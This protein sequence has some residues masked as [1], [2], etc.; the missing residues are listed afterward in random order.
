MPKRPRGGRDVPTLLIPDAGP[1]VSLAACDHLGLLLH[2]NCAITDVV[3]RETAGRAKSP[4]ASPEARAIAAFL[5]RHP[6]VEIRT[7]QL[8]Q[9]SS[10]ST[11]IRDLG[12]LSIHSLLIEF[13]SEARATGAVVLFEDHWFTERLAHFPPGVTCL[14]TAAFLMAAQA[15]GLL[16][17]AD[18]AMVAIRRTRPTV[19]DQPTT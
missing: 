12:E 11:G 9:L 10:G 4:T 17:S 7:T 3:W 5:E 13:R 18:E 2:F 16:A 1:L 19:G 15:L 8:G 6:E 14:G